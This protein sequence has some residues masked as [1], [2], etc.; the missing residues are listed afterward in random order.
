MYQL[1]RNQCEKFLRIP[2]EP[3]PP[4]GDESS[5]RLFRAAP[6]FYKYLVA[7]WG[8]QTLPAL[9]IPTVAVMLPLTIAAVQL[10]RRGT[11]AGLFLLIIPALIFAIILVERVFRLAV[12]RL[13]FE[14]R[15]YVVTDRSL[16]IR[17]G[18]L[19]VREM[20]VTFANIQNISI[21]QGPIQRMLGIADLDVETAGGGAAGHEHYGHS[22]PNLHMASFRGI[23]N[24]AEVRQLIEARL[25]KVKDSGLGDHEEV[26]SAAGPAGSQNV[27]EVL[28]QIHSEAAKLREAVA[29]G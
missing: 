29:R 21:S 27:I 19:N 18:V 10:N 20:T 12:V 13:D 9:L 5:T 7:I 11:K 28:N 6:N 4:P 24:A 1:F 15:W 22:G 26:A 16:R 8:L 23:D 25:K 17:E 2:P 14:K 3:E